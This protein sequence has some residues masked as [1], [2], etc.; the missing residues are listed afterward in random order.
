M[1]MKTMMLGLMVFIA[2]AATCRSADSV[3]TANAP[4]AVLDRMLSSQ[5]SGDYDAFIS[6]ISQDGFAKLGIKKDRDL[7]AT[8]AALARAVIKKY[9]TRLLENTGDRA[10]VELVS[11][12]IRDD[13][14][15]REVRT[16]EVLQMDG[17]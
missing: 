15:M 10:V 5:L 17:R 9:E 12:G 6:C 8:N 4:V 1:K 3:T 11:Y 16:F 14:G 7:F 13:Q 2:H